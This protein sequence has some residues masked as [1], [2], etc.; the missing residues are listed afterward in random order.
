MATAHTTKSAAIRAKLPHP[1]ID[2]DG[3]TAEFEPAL[4]DY[5][6]KIAGN[7]VVERFKNA[8]DVPFRFQWYKL[9]PQERR[10]RRALR[11]HWWVHPTKNTLDRAASSL[12]KLLHERLD[13]M[14]LDF[15]IIYPS[16][17][18][19][20]LHT[21]DEELRRVTCRAL[22]TYHAD[23]FRE[24]ADRMTPVAVIPMYTPQE[25]I[26]ELEYVVKEL[27]FK[28]ILMAAQV[29]RP[30]KAV[31]ASAPEL[32]R[33]AFWLDS[34]GID[35]EYDYDPVWAKCLELKVSPTFHSIGVG[36]GSRTSISNFMFNHIGHFAASA[37]AVCK[38]LFFGGVTRRFPQLRFAFL[39][40][41]V[42]W[43]STLF[44]D[45][46]G[47][48][49]KHN[50]NF[51]ENFN[52]ANLDEPLMHELFSK[53][54]DGALSP[55]KLANLEDRSQ[56]LWGSREETP[57][58]LDEWKPCKIDKKEDIRELF[59]PRFFFGCEGDDR[60]TPLA[61]DGKKHAFRS[62][63]NAIYGSDL[64][65]FDLPDMRDAAAE[66]YELVEKEWMSEEDFRD[67]VFV[68]PVKHKTDV[69]P[70]FFKG[71]VVEGAVKKL[72]AESQG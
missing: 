59:V 9:S 70:D 28:A 30:I 31:A 8:P 43:A 35:S 54:G 55:E 15:S 67:F 5:M 2:S 7:N 36:W 13:E 45:L 56:L 20:A 39:E 1:I 71:T 40:G 37:E 6:R 16:I 12:P 63:L 10:D 41:G 60:M 4:F 50:V 52:P 24:Y 33:Y 3:H 65:H 68:N 27:K 58:D 49:E 23:I 22:N 42:A 17:G 66:A 19:A 26:E 14:G 11:A 51:I 18:L 32:N 38:S 57:A 29:R 62:R 21:S 64:G 48:W 61:F 47:H 34:L 44:N 25:A 72:L 69:N 46:V 53:Y